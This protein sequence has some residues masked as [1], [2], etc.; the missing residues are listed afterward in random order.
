MFEIGLGVTMFSAIIFSLVLIIL[1]ARS[2]LVPS[3]K[4]NITVNEEKTIQTS[5][6]NKLLN[7]LAD[8]HLFVASACGGGGTCG[9]CRLKVFEGGGAI[10]PTETSHISKKQATDH[11]RLACQ[12]AVKQDMK[13]EV[14]Q[15]VFGVK[16]W[17]CTVKSNKNIASFIKEFVA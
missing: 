8:A 4:V 6:G 2:Y 17:V 1:A 14:P 10:L 13:I 16:K 15:E 12:V 9:Q 7:T 3:G 11:Y 5:V